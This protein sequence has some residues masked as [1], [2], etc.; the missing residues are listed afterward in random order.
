MESRCAH[1]KRRTRPSK[2]GPAH[3]REGESLRNASGKYARQLRKIRTQL[4]PRSE[5]FDV[6]RQRQEWPRLASQSKAPGRRVLTVTTVPAVQPLVSYSAS[7][8]PRA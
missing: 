6:K 5:A 4:N 7:S 3:T 8:S 2:A 1:E